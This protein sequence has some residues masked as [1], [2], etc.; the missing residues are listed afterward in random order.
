MITKHIK[1]PKALDLEGSLDF[2]LVTS[3][4]EEADEYIIDFADV[5]IIEPFGLLLVSS[6]IQRLIQHHPNSKCH[7]INYKRMTYAGTMGFF[8]AFGCEFG[9]APG[10]ALGSSRYIPI[11]ILNSDEMRRAAE[12]D[13]KQVGEVIEEKSKKLSNLLC[14]ASEGDINDTLTY[15]IREIIRN[16]I[17]HSES[18]QFGMCAQYWPSKNRVEV[19]IIDRGVGIKK[20]LSGNHHLTITDNK[21]A[22]NYALMPAIS[23]KAFKGS[24]VKQ[25]GPW[26]NSGFGLYMTN[27]ICRNGGTF[28]I[29]SGDTGML[30]TKGANAKKYYNCSFKGTA[31]R[32]VIKTDS[33]LELRLALE[34]FK[35]E[36]YEINK[37]YREITRIDPSSASLMLSED[38]DLSLWK[39][40]RDALRVN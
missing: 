32:M 19:A 9:K 7:F 34:K 36:G 8:K 37:T 17:E 27:R 3:E 5:G 26:A 2:S 21:S 28:F 35:N 22:I 39:K 11:N 4:V 31:V 1:L 12:A 38:F 25:K 40:L 18:N 33:L 10:E 13:D 15:S 30:L 14:G 23:G 6:E 20:T 24:R 16:I 29:A